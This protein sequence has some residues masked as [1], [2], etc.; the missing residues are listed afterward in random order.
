V[1]HAGTTKPA[2]VRRNL[3]SSN[4]DSF[5]AEPE[6]FTLEQYHRQVPEP[7][8]VLQER[9]WTPPVVEIPREEWRERGACVGEEPTV[10]LAPRDRGETAVA[11]C[12]SC[13]VRVDCYRWIMGESKRCR[14][15]YAGMVIAGLVWTSNGTPV[16]LRT[17]RA[18]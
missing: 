10:W 11:I 4:I 12:E 13:E 5:C 18:S 17:R 8:V 2:H 15:E 1:T 16:R 7:P 6:T 9:R 3:K 14:G